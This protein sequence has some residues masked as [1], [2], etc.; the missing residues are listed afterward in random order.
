MNLG[1]QCPARVLKVD[2]H[3]EIYFGFVMW[4]SAKNFIP[5]AHTLTMLSPVPSAA[6]SIFR[7][8]STSQLLG[9]SAVP[10]C[11]GGNVA[12]CH[13]GVII[14]IHQPSQVGVN[15]IYLHHHNLWVVWYIFWEISPPGASA[16]TLKILNLKRNPPVQLELWTSQKAPRLRWSENY[17][18]NFDTKNGMIVFWAKRKSPTVQYSTSHKKTLKIHA[19]LVS[20]QIKAKVS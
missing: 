15:T 3:N 10:P 9:T 11:T 17:C 4:A 20:T 6:I 12:T 18:W 2:C 16:T 7:A 14:H 5:F 13:H 1:K 8:I 19:V